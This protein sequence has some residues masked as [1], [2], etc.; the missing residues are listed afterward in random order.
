[1]LLSRRKTYDRRQTY[2]LAGFRKM[3]PELNSSERYV[4]LNHTRQPYG[5]D[6]ENVMG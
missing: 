3:L 4:T 2:D 5:G 6:G 1:M